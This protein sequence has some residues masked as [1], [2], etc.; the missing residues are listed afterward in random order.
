MIKRTKF[1]AAFLCLTLAMCAMLVPVSAEDNI[2]VTVNG[3]AV[4]FDAKPELT[5]GRTMVPMHAIFEALGSTVTFDSGVVTGTRGDTVITLTEG[6]TD[7][8]VQTADGEE[9]ITLD[10]APYIKEERIYVPARFIAESLD[11]QVSWDPSVQ[12]VIV[13]DLAKLKADMTANSDFLAAFLDMPLTNE[14]AL[15]GDTTM[16]FS[17]VFS[18]VPEVGDVTLSLD[19]TVT[20]QTQGVTSNS[21]LAASLDLTQLPAFM[22]QLE[23]AIPEENAALFAEPITVDATML[24]D[25]SLNLYVKVN[26]MQELLD[27]F[28]ENEVTNAIDPDAWYK[29]GTQ[30]LMD[31]LSQTSGVTM[32]D[33]STLLTSG[34][35]WEYLVSNFTGRELTAT[36]SY[37]INNLYTT[38]T[39]L[40]GNDVMQATTL[41]DG[42]TRY[43]LSIDKDT[44]FAIS[45]QSAAETMDVSV[46]ELLAALEEDPSYAGMVF[47]IDMTM[48]VNE[49]TQKADMTMEISVP[50]TETD[51]APFSAFGMK[52]TMTSQAAPMEEGEV[53]VEVPEESVDLVALLKEMGFA[54]STAIIGGADGPTA[55]ITGEDDATAQHLTIFVPAGH[56]TDMS[57]LEQA[58]AQVNTTDIEIIQASDDYTDQSYLMVAAGEPAAF[59]P[60]G[61]WDAD[62]VTNVVGQGALLPLDA[63]LDLAPTAK[64]YVDAH[65]ELKAE[66]GKLYALPVVVDGEAQENAFFYVSGTVN[67]ATVAQA[68]QVFEAYLA[69]LG[70]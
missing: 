41:E 27:L 38:Y 15:S 26:N 28:G 18:D 52:F 40:F 69:L 33:M 3:K 20:E 54:S 49:D 62:T 36:D 2:T 53:T 56:E 65:P 29:L 55:I 19:L 39:T 57:L 23:Q 24:V 50:M 13:L 59:L 70:E 48:D 58:V 32:P 5:N 46:E 30:D 51:Q 6:Q 12:Q 34:T 64:A 44:L 22:E 9:T 4:T 42:T 37:L 45:L 17:L 16:A 8:T 11:A 63:Y 21:G 7:A 61:A 67:D 60:F 47:D 43:T 25:A 1:I 31:L 35:M 68:M 14:T 10:A 66:D